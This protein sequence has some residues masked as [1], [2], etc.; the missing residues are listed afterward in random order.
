MTNFSTN[1]RVGDIVN[2]L[3]CDGEYH[4][5]TVTKIGKAGYKVRWENP[6]EGERKFDILTG[7]QTMFVERAENHQT[8]GG[9]YL[10][11]LYGKEDGEYR[12]TKL[13]IS[14]DIRV[15][16]SA[17]HQGT[18]TYQVM[19]RVFLNKKDRA[20][21]E[22]MLKVWVADCLDG[23]LIDGST[24]YISK[25]IST[26]HVEDMFDGVYEKFKELYCN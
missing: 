18:E 4:R 7:Q 1:A 3:Y 6:G 8:N 14:H 17:Y 16:E 15:R 25:R 9:V 26:E 24:E 13:G 22:K 2:V 19:R 12:G 23:W 21:F 20:M 11:A 10:V 5:G